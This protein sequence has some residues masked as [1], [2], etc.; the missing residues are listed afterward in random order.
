MA[1]PTYTHTHTHTHTHTRA[2][3][4]PPSPR[5]Q[6]FFPSDNLDVKYRGLYV[7][8]VQLLRLGMAGYNLFFANS[9]PLT[10]RRGGGGGAGEE[11]EGQEEGGGGGLG[12]G[13]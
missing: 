13:G 7:R 10:V 5:R 3:P 8:V 11:E 12:G 1:F 2:L 4:L 6:V 9:Y